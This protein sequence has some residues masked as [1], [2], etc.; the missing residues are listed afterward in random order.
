[1]SEQGL[2]AR[3]EGVQPRGELVEHL[4]VVF[5]GGTETEAVTTRGIGVVGTGNA[6]TTKGGVVRQ[7][8]GERGHGTVVVGQ[9]DNGGRGLATAHGVEVGELANQLFVLH[10][11]LPQK[12]YAGA[13]VRLVLVH[14]ND[15]IEENAEVGTAVGSAVG[16]N[17]GGQMSA[18]REA[19]DAH[20]AGIDTP[21]GGG[22]AD[23]ADG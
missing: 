21:D 19:H 17:G 2:L 20:V 11:L 7:P 13:F 22:V 5:E 4:V 8:V 1:M 16:R 10:T 6:S 14:G 9:Q 12:S 15:G 3:F 23:D 18:S